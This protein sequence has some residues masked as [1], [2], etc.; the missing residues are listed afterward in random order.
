MKARILLDW[1]AAAV[2][3]AAIFVV[4]AILFQARALV[5]RVSP[6]GYI[7]NGGPLMLV[8]FEYAWIN[9]GGYKG[10]DGLHCC[11]WQDCM[12]VPADSVKPNADG[13]SYSTPKGDI[14]NKGIY[15]SRDG[16]TWICRFQGGPPK[17]LFVPGGG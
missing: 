4:L 5:P 7:G 6:F 2:S 12:E 13:Q 10:T 11:G 16:K 8:H 14:G 15:Y 17:C 9:D 3:L 1:I